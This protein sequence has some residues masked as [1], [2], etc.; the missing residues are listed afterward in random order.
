MVHSQH[1]AFAYPH[2]PLLT[3]P[4]VVCQAGETLLILGRSGKGK[5]TLLQLLAG[6]RQVQQGT[7]SIA[8]IDL[9]SLS[10]QE[11]DRFRGRHIGLVFQQSH[12]LRA[13]TVGENLLLAQHL[14][15]MPHDKGR[16]Q[17]L[18][19]QLGVGDKLHQKPFRLSVGEQQ[20][21]AI[22]RALLNQPHMILADEPTSALDDHHCEEVLQLLQNQSRE[23]GA[24][25]LI[26]THDNRLKSKIPHH[27][28]LV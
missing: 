22:A 15:G 26:V 23:V 5:T 24:A 18:L 6:L 8:G 14:A 25:L 27:I 7:I 19:D 9:A 17:Q 1:L 12:F 4:D 10:A 13:L 16:I 11:R 28:E 21:V 2:Q 20:R 3:F